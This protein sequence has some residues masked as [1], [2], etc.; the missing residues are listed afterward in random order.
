MDG[1]A[2]AP[3]KSSS[4]ATCVSV[5][6]SSEWSSQGLLTEIDDDEITSGSDNRSLHILRGRFI[7]VDE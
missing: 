7:R 2:P 6:Q 1:C 3:G 5:K 4:P